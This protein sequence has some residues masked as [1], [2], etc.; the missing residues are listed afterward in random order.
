MEGFVTLDEIG[1]EEDADSQKQRKSGKVKSIL[2]NEETVTENKTEETE[3]EN[4]T[5]ENGSK[6]E[7]EKLEISEVTD[8][9]D[10]STQEKEQ[11]ENTDVQETKIVQEKRAVPDEHRIGPYQPN[12]PVGKNA[13]SSPDVICTV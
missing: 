11:N 12:V 1:D 3:Q 7:N 8:N 10:S 13:L 9:T 5:L 6:P 4:E 2:K